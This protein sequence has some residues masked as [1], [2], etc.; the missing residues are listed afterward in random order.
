MNNEINDDTNNAMNNDMNDETTNPETT[1]GSDEAIGASLSA[2]IRAHV[3]APVEKPP[4]S[5]IAKRAEAR[6]RARAVRRTVVGVAASV[7]LLAGG[8]V[9]YSAFDD[10]GGSRIVAIE[11]ELRSDDAPSRS[12]TAEPPVD[13]SSV[14]ENPV[15][16]PSTDGPAASALAWTEVGDG[17]LGVY[18]AVYQAATVGDGRVLARAFGDSGTE[19]IVSDNGADWTLLSM[20]DGIAADFIDVSSPRWLVGQAR[21]AD[22]AGRFFYSDDEGGSWAELTFEPAPEGEPLHALTSGNSMMIVFRVPPDRDGHI[23]LIQ[24]LIAASGVV[25][26][27]ATLESWAIESWT[28]QGTTVSFTIAGSGASFSFEISDEERQALDATEGD[29]RIRVYA[30]DGGTARAT[31]EYVS[32]NTSASSN[33]SGFS[34]AITTPDD[35]LLLS[36]VDGAAWTETSIDGINFPDAYDSGLLATN[37][38]GRW[39]VERWEDEIRVK[40]LDQLDDPRAATATMRGIA[41]L[42]SFAT[43]PAGMVATAFAAP[44]GSA[45]QP[46]LLGWSTD[47]AVWEWQPLTEAFGVDEVEASVEFAV[48]TDFFLAQVTEFTSADSGA[49]EAEITKWFQAKPDPANSR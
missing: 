43:G 22:S 28:L 30:G 32:W 5:L 31:A 1:V 35:E 26:D 17:E 29:T 34:I 49:L 27:D 23:T 12:S 42:E 25:P 2:A 14:G 6:A 11:A 15:D 37:R 44:P 41:D 47:G 46:R 39:V 48:G 13:G 24:Q 18:Q 36:S 10:Q 19:I 3:D 16:G 21:G 8:L 40:S 38:D 33:A 45:Q 9:A 7:T 4:V 20:P